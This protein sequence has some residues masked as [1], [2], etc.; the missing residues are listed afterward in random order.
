MTRSDPTLFAVDFST[1]ISNNVFYHSQVARIVSENYQDGDLIILWDHEYKS[2]SKTR[3]DEVTTNRQG[4][5]GTSPIAIAQAALDIGSSAQGRLVLITDGEVGVKSIDQCD[6]FLKTHSLSFTSV[7]GFIIGSEGNLS[8]LCPFTRT[9]PHTICTITGAGTP[10]EIVRVSVADQAILA[11]IGEI[12]TMKA[13]TTSYDSLKRALTARTLGT[14]GDRVLRDQVIDMQNRIVRSLG[15]GMPEVGPALRSALE[16]GRLEEALEYG[17]QLVGAHEIGGSFSSQ[18]N[19]LIRMCEGAIR[20][21]FDPGSIQAARASR[22]KDAIEFDATDAEDVE[23]KAGTFVCPIYFDDETDP[24]ILIA[25]PERPLL[26]GVGPK[27]VNQMID[28]PLNAAIKQ[29]FMTDFVAH[30][31]HVVSLK[32]LREAAAS[33]A[34]ITASPMTRRSVL[35]AIPLGA[36]L[37]HAIAADW[38]LS[39]L[40]SG[41]KRLGNADCWFAVLWLALE[42]GEIPYLSEMLPF[43]REQMIWRLR[44]RYSSAALTG[45]AGFC[46]KRIPLGCA[47]WFVLASPAFRVQPELSFDPLRLHLMHPNLLRKMLDLLHYPLPDRINRHIKR[48]RALFSLLNYCKWNEADLRAYVRGVHQRWAYV[49]RGKVTR[50]LFRR[51][52]EVP[53]YVPIDGEPNDKQWQTIRD[54]FPRRCFAMSREELVWLAG[55]V[56]S[57]LSAGAIPLKLT[58]DP[59]PIPA[60]VEEWAPYAGLADRFTEVQICP[61]TMRPFYRAPDGKTWKEHH[62]AIVAVDDDHRLSLCYLY[63]RCVVTLRKYPTVEEFIEF[64]FNRTVRSGKKATLV[65]DPLTYFGMTVRLFERVTRG[66]DPQVFIWRFESSADIEKREAM[67]KEPPQDRIKEKREAVLPPKMKKGNKKHT[68]ANLHGKP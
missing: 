12:R 61:S 14:V 46:Q 23:S 9:C 45:L 66:V 35:G 7:A 2:V 52:D 28:C 30:V 34:P 8:V 25:R 63:G 32:A 10:V 1:S 41:G 40:L 55:M 17:S 26:F 50:D 27:T 16:S 33:K 62:V 68:A 44:Y 67:E 18:M 60:P 3:L 24:A 58:D 59:P 37:T 15:M 22:A 57:N 65:A 21:T 48:L 36:C 4:G 51:P 38:T 43:V 64:A 13:F 42:R 56:N 31:D 47:I 54:N 5:G 49:D 19:E 29:H 20:L 6:A 11:Q 53:L 39:Q